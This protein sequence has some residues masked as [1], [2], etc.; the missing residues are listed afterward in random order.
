M[1]IKMVL[2]IKKKKKKKKKKKRRE[3]LMANVIVDNQIDQ[4]IVRR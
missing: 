1:L 4:T 3:Q 2:M